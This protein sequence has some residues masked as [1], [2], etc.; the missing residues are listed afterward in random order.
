[1]YKPKYL[2]HDSEQNFGTELF[3]TYEEALAYYNEIK[4]D[5]FNWSLDEGFINDGFSVYI[6][7]V[8]MFSEFR[9]DKDYP[10]YKKDEHGDDTDVE[11]GEYSYTLQDIKVEE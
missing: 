1:M 4:D 2:V 3:N 7:K 10:I 11:T 6:C 8:M 5:A 9:E